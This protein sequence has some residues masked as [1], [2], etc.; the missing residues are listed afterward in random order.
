M[1]GLNKEEIIDISKKIG[2]YETSIMP[3]P[4]CCS[5]MIADHPKTKASIKEIK[6]IEANIPNIEQLIEDA[7]SSVREQTFIYK[8]E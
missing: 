6:E 7:L 8:K 1:I 2:T 5:F 4:D 3:Y